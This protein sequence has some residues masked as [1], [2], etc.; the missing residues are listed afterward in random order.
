MPKLWDN[1]LVWSP[2]HKGRDSAMKHWFCGLMAL[3]LLQG[4]AGQVKAQPTYAFA[5]LDVPG[6]SYVST[7]PTGINASGQIVG[8]YRDAAGWHGFLLDQGSYTTLDVPGA[9]RTFATGINASGQIVGSYDDAAGTH[10]F[11]LDQGS[12]TTLDF[13][14]SGINNLG[15]IVGGNL[16]YDQGC[17]ITLDVPGSRGTSASGINDSGQIVGGYGDAAGTNHGFLATPAP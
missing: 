17:Y 9:I 13:V 1:L 12:Y 5:T 4:V 10:G 7:S 14:P 11:L 6:S 2:R 8:G 15:Q 3:G 16:L